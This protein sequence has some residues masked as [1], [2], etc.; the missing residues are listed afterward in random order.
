MVKHIHLYIC[1]YSN[2]FY[3]SIF[4][5]TY[6]MYL[7]QGFYIW[8]RGKGGY[9]YFILIFLKHSQ[10]FHFNL[11]LFFD[12]YYFFCF[13]VQ[14]EAQF[15]I[16]YCHRCMSP[17]LPADKQYRVYSHVTGFIVNL[18]QHVIEKNQVKQ[19]SIEILQM[20]YMRVSKEQQ[21]YI[22]KSF[23]WF[24]FP[25]LYNSKLQDYATTHLFIFQMREEFNQVNLQI[26]RW[27]IN[28]P[29]MSH[30]QKT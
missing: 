12:F 15:Q 29:G 21:Y 27:L 28:V 26:N 24:K 10:Y 11:S 2:L 16:S 17:M 18:E 1:L 19:I 9:F 25:V 30:K 20:V 8:G 6:I 5:M 3:Q 4:R 7:L 13:L 23:Y 22:T 14:L